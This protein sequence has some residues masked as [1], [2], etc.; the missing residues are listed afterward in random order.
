MKKKKSKYAP[1]EICVLNNSR[2]D[3]I[4]IHRSMNVQCDGN[5]VKTSDEIV[6][7]SSVGTYF[8][9]ANPLQES[10]DRSKI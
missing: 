4:S 1:L 3:K 2:D 8:C 6:I 5:D 10:G 9:L 7:S